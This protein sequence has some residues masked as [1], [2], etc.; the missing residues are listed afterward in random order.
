MDRNSIIGLAII[1]LLIIGMGIINKPAR[2]A[3]EAER[4][5]QVTEMRRQDS[6]ARVEQQRATEAAAIQPGTTA[7]QEGA[8]GIAA[9]SATGIQLKNRY[10]DFASLASGT[11]EKVTIEN[12]QIRLTFD[13]KGGRPYTVDLKKY[14]TYDSLPLILFDG[15][16]TV[17]ALQFFAAGRMGMYLQGSPCAHAPS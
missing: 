7:E 5:R 15:D 17:F 3:R 11:E 13:T 4:R 6:L 16:S 10:G 2:E 12:E 1:G 14:Q 8:E 9:D